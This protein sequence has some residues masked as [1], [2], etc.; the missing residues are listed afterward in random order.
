[1]R[2][3][4]YTPDH[5]GQLAEI[6][7]EA[8]HTIAPSCYT[9]EQKEAWAPTPPD[10]LA[11][12]K[13]LKDKHVFMAI[14]DNLVIGFIELDPDGHI[15]CMYTLPRYQNC[16]V[17]SRLYNHIETFAI[18]MNIK[19]LY[20]EAS[21]VARPFFEKHGFTLLHKNEVKRHGSILVNYSMEKIILPEKL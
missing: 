7:H 3:C 2:I 21:I 18:S 10:Y 20:V 6:F 16:G 11:W 8:V 5:A 4:N 13:R 17:A 14:T 9:Q 12:S 19:H 1:M 15:D